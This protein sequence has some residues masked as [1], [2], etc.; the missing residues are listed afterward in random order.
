MNKTI[1]AERLSNKKN[2][3]NKILTVWFLNKNNFK[4]TIRVKKELIIAKMVEIILSF[5]GKIKQTNPEAKGKIKLS[6]N[7]LFIYWTIYS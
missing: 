6:K 4:Q 7:K 2:L 5:L 3:S 1:D